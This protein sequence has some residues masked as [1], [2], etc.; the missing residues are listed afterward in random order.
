MIID[1]KDKIKIYSTGTY[2][3]EEIIKS[4]DIFADI[5]TEIKYGIP[6]SWMSDQMG[7]IERRVAPDCSA[8]S[9]LAIP[10]AQEAIDNLTGVNPD[11][12]DLVIFCGIERD[13]PEPATAHTIQNALGLNA[14][15]VFDVANACYGFMDGIETASAY[16]SAGLARYALIVT[17]EISFKI[18]RAISDHL[19]NAEVTLPRARQ[20][21]GGLSVGDAGGAVIVGNSDDGVSGFNFFNTSCDSRHVDK[22]FYKRKPDG[23]LEGQMLMAK[24]VAYGMRMHRGLMKEIMD[25]KGFRDYDWLITHQTGKRNFNAIAEMGVIDKQHMTKTYDTLGNVTTATFAH[26]FKL[27]CSGN[28]QKG[29]RVGGWFAGSGLTVGQF[30]YTT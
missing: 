26:N 20:L 25:R 10:A 27:L 29:S 15:K 16:I 17:G 14:R 18:S 22:C 1:T 28:I 4:D 23:S 6:E 11:H 21:L 3:P 8:P 19:K 7:I 24:I 12:I 5:K 9:S 30:C 13:Q 2:L